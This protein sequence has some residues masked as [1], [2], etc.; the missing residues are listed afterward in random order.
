MSGCRFNTCPIM[1]LKQNYGN[2]ETGSRLLIKATDPAFGK[3]VA[4]WCQM[5]GAKLID[6]QEN[7]GMVQALVEKVEKQ[8]EIHDMTNLKFPDNK[9]MIVFSDDLDKALASFVLAN[10]ALAAGKKV[11]MFFTFWGLNI[12]KKRQ[13]PAV[14]KDIFGK[15]FGMSG[16]SGPCGSVTNKLIFCPTLLRAVNDSPH[17]TIFSPGESENTGLMLRE[18]SLP[19]R[20]KLNGSSFTW[21]ESLSTQRRVLVRRRP[22]ASYSKMRQG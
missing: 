6:V 11:T 4:S 2:I 5:M 12:I 13:K 14:H 7:K 17:P 15:M 18:L 19:R 8:P 22:L 10:G 3:D 21:V 16:V 20:I 9:T 1:K